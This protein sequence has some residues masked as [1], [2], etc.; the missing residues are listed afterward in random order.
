MYD[1][2]TDLVEGDFEQALFCTD[3]ASGLRSIIVIHNTALGPALGGVR[4]RPYGTTGE[5]LDDCLRLARAMTYKAAVAGLDQGGGKSVIIGD[6]VRDKTPEVLR[7]H[8][9]FIETLKGRYVPGIDMGTTQ[10]DLRTIGEETEEVA[11]VGGDPA[12]Y[13]ALGVYHAIRSGVEFAL[14]RDGLDGLRISIQGVGNVG[15]PL[16]RLAAADG[17][18]LTVADTRQEV[19]EGVASEVGATTVPPEEIL[20]SACDV[21]APCAA[22]GA[23]TED[24]VPHLRCS[25][26]AGATNNVLATPEAGTRLHSEGITY[27]PDYV[28]NCGGILFLA[29]EALGSSP[30]RMRERMGDVGRIAREVLRRSDEDGVPSSL[31]AERVAEERLRQSTTPRPYVGD[32]RRKYTRRK[33]A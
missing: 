18:I 1:V 20:T 24:L 23:I 4:M 6:P 31:A 8:G 13:T 19:A 10:E 17:A 11:G 14:G 7:A 16:A 25:V 2:V 21:L 12:A 29:E 3:N 27:V 5:A 28:A 30:E 15:H 32:G 22:G 26:V 33:F 9:R